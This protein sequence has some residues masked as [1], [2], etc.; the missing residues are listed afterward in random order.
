MAVAH[1]KNTRKPRLWAVHPIKNIT[2]SLPSK[3]SNSKIDIQALKDI[4]DGK[5]QTTPVFKLFFDPCI[6]NSKTFIT[7]AS[8]K[9]A[10]GVP[11]RYFQREIGWQQYGLCAV[12]VVVEVVVRNAV[13]GVQ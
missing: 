7:G 1:T 10:W 8:I 9:V 2:K 5:L 4:I 3:G 13:I 6:D 11:T 12:K